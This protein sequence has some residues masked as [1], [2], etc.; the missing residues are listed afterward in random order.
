MRKHKP[1]PIYRAL[2]KLAGLMPDGAVQAEMDP[3][4]FLADV[5]EKIKRADATIAAI[6][7]ECN[8]GGWALYTGYVL[9]NRIKQ[10][11]NG[12]KQ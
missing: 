2:C 8:D 1:E 10:I 6:L 9:A 4:G 12:A 3:A 5:S 7:E 11:I